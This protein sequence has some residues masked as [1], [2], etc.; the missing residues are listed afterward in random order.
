LNDFS[1]RKYIFLFNIFLLAE[2]TRDVE[3]KISSAADIS[4]SSV[5]GVITYPVPKSLKLCKTIKISDGCS[6]VCS[7]GGNT[8]VGIQYCSGG[9]VRI[10]REFNVTELVTSGESVRAVAVYKDK[11]YAL[12]DSYVQ[13]SSRGNPYSEKQ[14][15]VKVYTLDGNQ[16][17]SWRHR[18]KSESPSQL[19]VIDGQVVIP[20]RGSKMITVYSL[21][22]EV[23]KHIP[24]P[25]LNQY[26]DVI[27]AAAAT[28]DRHCVVVSNSSQ[29]FKLDLKTEKVIWTCKDVT[30]PGGVTCYRSGYIFV[31]NQDI[32]TNI[33]I[34]D[35]KTG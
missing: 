20:D 18:G 34:L 24:C 15:H 26:D 17:T 16:V 35:V 14:Y 10:D 33:W 4:V 19:M 28:A 6:S 13:S 32:T 11:L 8:Y 12:T 5:H 9:I 27:C 2:D 22:G 29:V 7:Y 25:L 23:V 31:T 21:V 3:V 1:Y 30:Y